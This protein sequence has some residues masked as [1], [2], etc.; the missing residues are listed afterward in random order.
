MMM[1]MRMTTMATTIR[2]TIA[3]DDDKNNKV[4]T[5]AMIYFLGNNQPWL[6]AFLAEGGWVIST[7]MTTMRMT[8]MVTTMRERRL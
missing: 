5:M 4:T 7:M 2:E 1:T 3:A 8:T 6:G